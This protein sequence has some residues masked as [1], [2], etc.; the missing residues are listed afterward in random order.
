M[1]QDVR[2][3][4]V[5][6][7]WAW[8]IIAGAKDIEN[9]SWSTDYRGPVVILASSTKSVVSRIARAKQS[10]PPAMEFA[11]G[12]LIGV[13]DLLDVVPL[14][15]ELEGNR[16]AW[17]PYC[18]KVGHAKRF[19]K[20]IPAK[21]MLNLYKLAPDL[22]GKA[23][24]AIKTAETV[25]RSRADEAWVAAMLASDAPDQRDDGVYQSYF[26]LGDGPGMLR[27]AERMVAARGTADAYAN[28]GWTNMLVHDYKS[29][30]ADCS[31]ALKLDPENLSGLAGRR[32]VH[33]RMGRDDLAARDEARIRELDPDMADSLPPLLPLDS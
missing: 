10:R 32:S 33:H 1:T 9:R 26:D 21:G 12:A 17:G 14:S 23:T 22:A 16:W 4:A 18:W 2:C 13:V 20:P 29:A 8:A 25:R 3:L 11:Y 24:A 7:P 28:R 5:R 19:A 30:L 31:R 15:E 27:V 6:Q